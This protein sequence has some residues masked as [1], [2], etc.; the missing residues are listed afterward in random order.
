MET[1]CDMNNYIVGS[2]ITFEGEQ[3]TYTVQARDSRFIVCTKP[4][5][6]GD[7][8]YY[9]IVDLIEN[10]RGADSRVFTKGY[11]TTEQCEHALKELQEGKLRVSHRNR[12]GLNI[13][14]VKV[15]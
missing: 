13:K 1:N 2:K 3:G 5:K 14:R 12:I 9:T 8:V 4:Y 7:T 15:A 11:E 6:K 10:I